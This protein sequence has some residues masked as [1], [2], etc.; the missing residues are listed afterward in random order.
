[1]S[2]FNAI[3][4]R[5]T[6]AQ[7]GD[8]T[9]KTAALTSLTGIVAD[10]VYRRINMDGVTSAFIAVTTHR[11]PDDAITVRPTR[12]FTVTFTIVSPRGPEIAAT[13]AASLMTLLDRQDNEGNPWDGVTCRFFFDGSDEDVFTGV[14]NA[15]ELYFSRDEVYIAHA[16]TDQ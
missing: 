12:E 3:F 14:G 8:T 9:E 13:V 2:L 4:E 6:K 1:M 10:R 11:E 7:A 15:S 16:D 5:L